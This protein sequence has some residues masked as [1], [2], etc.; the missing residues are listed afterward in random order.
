MVTSIIHA[1]KGDPRYRPYIEYIAT[2]PVQGAV[3]G[4]LKIDPKNRL[5]IDSLSDMN[6]HGHLT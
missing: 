4:K 2:L 3:Y 1:L 6:D 5:A